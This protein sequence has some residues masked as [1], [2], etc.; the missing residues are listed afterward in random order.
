MA[1]RRVKYELGELSRAEAASFGTPGRRTFRLELQ[2][3]PA[4]CAIWLE[5]EQLFQL[6]VYL[7][8]SVAAL[9]AAE[10][11]RASRPAEPAWNGGDAS[12]DFKVGQ[13]FISYDGE[14]NAY[15]VQ[16]HELERD[17]PPG[18]PESVSFWLTVG[19]ARALAETALQICASGRPTCFLCGMPI[20]PEGHACPR[21]NAHTIL[22]TG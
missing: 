9:P 21:A 17:D 19:Q 22:E 2:S 7:R 3:G 15:Y 13:M 16:S 12:I 11:E 18:D 6:A 4:D 8:D 20:N 14:A 5:K 10:R 1:S